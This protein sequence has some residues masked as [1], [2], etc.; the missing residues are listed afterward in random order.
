MAKQKIGILGDGNVGSALQRGLQRAGHETKAVGKEQAAMRDT[1]AWGDVIIL[2]VPFGALDEVA[3]TAGEAL[4]GKTV[5][6]VTNAL[7]PDMNLAV[8]HTTS[9]A[10]E[11][12]KKLPRARVVKAFNTVFAQHMD[13]GRIGDQRLGA[14]VAGDDA[15]AKATVL[16]LAG[17]I[18]FDAVDAGPLRSAR[19]LEPMAL[20]NIQLGYVQ[21]LGLKIGFKLLRSPG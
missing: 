12:Q 16:A 2:A 18:G 8:G 1:A 20:L 4:A 15:Q 6:D 5:V 9:G 14:F 17:D 3:R 7:G 21:K 11:L 19:L 10:E 13:S